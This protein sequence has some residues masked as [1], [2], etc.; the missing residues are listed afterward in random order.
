MITRSTRPK[1]AICRLP[2]LA[3]AVLIRVFLPVLYCGNTLLGESPLK[4]LVSQYCISCHNPEERKGKLDLESILEVDL[5]QHIEVW[6][7]VAWMLR[8]REMPPEDEPDEPRPSEAEYETSVNW[9]DRALE[10]LHAGDHSS[11]AISSK[12]A[13]VDK[14]CISC[15]N[16]QERKGDMDLEAIRFDDVLQHAEIWENVITRLQSRQMPPPDRKRPNEATYEALVANLSNTLDE[17]ANQNPQPGRTETFRRLNRT[18]Y[19]NAIRDLLALE[20]DAANLLPKDEESFGFD[21]VTVGTLSPSLLDRYISAAQKVSRLAVGASHDKPRGDTFRMPADYTQEKHVE[22][23][24]LGTRGGTLLPYT[25]AQDGEYEIEIRLMRDRNEHVEGLR[26]PHE[27]EIL[28]DK[29]I[30]QRFTIELPTDRQDHSAVDKHLKTRIFVKA[31]PRNLGVTFLKYT[32]S[33]SENKRQPFEAHFNYHRH[34]RLSPA[35]YQISIT[36]PYRGQ[37]ADRTPSRE[38]IFIRYPKKPGEEETVAREILANLMR[39]AYRRPI[40]EVDLRRPMSFYREEA[41][42]AG[43]EA[44]IETALSSILVNPEFIFRIEREPDHV[45][46]GR[47]YRISDLELA[48]R[49]SF[50]IWSSIPDD[51][52]LAEAIEGNLSQPDVLEKQ[53]RRMLADGRSSNLVNNFAGQWLHLRNLESIVPDLRLFPDFDDNL[54]QAFRRETELFIE[55]VLREDRSVLD[56]LKANYTYLNERLA[57]HYGIPHIF[58]SRFRRVE[59]DPSF[60]RGGLL[61]QGSIL[62]V[63]SYATRT[64]PVIRG[65]WVLENIIG[66]P[67]PPPLPDV[68]ALDENRVDASLSVRKRLE[69]HRANPACATCHNLM[70][71]IGF[72]L[73]NFDATGRWRDFE[74]GEALDVSG[75]LPDGSVFEGVANLEDG[76]RERPELFVRTLSQKLL[77]FALG[78]GVEFYDAPAI[79]DIVREAKA[80]EYRFSSIIL[81]ITQSVPFQMR[82]KLEE[83]YASTRIIDK[84]TP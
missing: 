68:P 30:V 11:V 84:I 71:P 39:R 47:A 67:P 28:L 56:L 75:G 16:P 83:E 12:L 7:E 42:G 57:H 5:S 8:E 10:N 17:A 63:T 80:N 43:F 24:P 61:R 37:G 1:F 27:M 54:R 40:S 34:P 15:H 6:D 79:R 50:F 70:D 3:A 72:A 45:K 64:S 53:V 69:M 49:L 60:K 14:F 52:L 62:T 78:R 81:G 13:V 4:N 66:T 46:P 65:N 44:G 32:F 22:G 38:K 48:T 25:F 58:G 36:G 31:G 41:K 77:T 82:T 55:S 74:N 2:G 26:G 23:L 59:L 33:L 18:E 51:E 9:L 76:L 21:N 19:Q 29:E 35:V 73:E 20:I